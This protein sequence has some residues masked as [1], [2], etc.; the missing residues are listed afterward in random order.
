[1]YFISLSAFLD[2]DA[3]I[4]HPNILVVVI[5]NGQRLAFTM[6]T[7][8]NG[9]IFRVTGPLCGE[10]TG[11]GEFPTQRP[12]TRSF[13]VFFDRRL[14]KRSSKPPRGWWLETLSCSLWRQSNAPRPRWT[15]EEPGLRPE[16]PQ[17][18]QNCDTWGHQQARPY[19][20]SRKTLL[21]M[22]HEI[23]SNTAVLR[24]LISAQLLL[25]LPRDLNKRWEHWEQIEEWKKQSIFHGTLSS[26]FSIRVE[27]SSI[28]RFCSYWLLRTPF[29]CLDKN[30][31]KW[32]TRYR[33]IPRHFGSQALFF[34]ST[35]TRKFELRMGALVDRKANMTLRCQASA[36]VGWVNM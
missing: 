34:A 1:M 26:L 31:S 14:N 35:R 24:V 30:H 29:C 2:N 15:Y 11:P 3:Y 9:N 36:S 20:P 28:T 32:T 13:D 27:S 19:V 5:A 23:S 21:K 10:F 16:Y 4:F 22:G 12:V 17:E 33:E 18:H 6:M 8:S 7:S 25:K